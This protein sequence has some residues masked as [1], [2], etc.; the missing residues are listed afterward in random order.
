V[1]DEEKAVSIYVELPGE[2]RD[3]IQLNVT[4]DNAEIKTS[5]FYKMIRLPKRDILPEKA[6]S[7]Y[8]NGI[9]KIIIPKRRKTR[10]KSPKR[11]NID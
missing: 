3:D 10:K 2:D 6:T 5:S 9:L 7:K 4:A 11:I 1:F 8:M